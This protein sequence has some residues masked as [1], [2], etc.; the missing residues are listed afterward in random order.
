MPNTMRHPILL[1]STLGWHARR[2]GNTFPTIFSVP[3]E[4]LELQ[5]ARTPEPSRR[6]GR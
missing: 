2:R 5:A 4:L 6:A 3:A 1:G